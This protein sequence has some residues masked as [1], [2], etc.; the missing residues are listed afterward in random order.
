ME[1]ELIVLAELTDGEGREHTAPSAGF[2][3]SL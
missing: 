2:T 1:V 3:L